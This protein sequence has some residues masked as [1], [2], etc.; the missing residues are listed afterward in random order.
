MNFDEYKGKVIFVGAG[1]GAPDLITV[2]GAEAVKNADVIIYAGSLVNPAI[3]DMA[4]DDAKIYDSAEMNLDEIIDVI[5]TAH[6]EN[7]I[8]ARVHT[9]DPSIYG[10][11]AEQIN[12]L[13]ELDIEFTIIPGVSSLFGTAA[14]LESQLTLPE[15]SQTIIITRPEGRTPKPSKEALAKLATHNATMCI[16]LGIHMIEEVVEELKKEYDAKTPVA[17]VKKATW[18]DQE[19][20]RGNLDNIAQ[21]VHEAGFTKT[22]MIV[23]GDVLD[24][25]SGEQSKLYDP[26]FAHMYRDAKDDE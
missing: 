7:K 19:I 6:E 20:L 15:V 2:R 14:A 11:I 12:Q 13:R 21:K 10:A 8:T 16:F 1:P 22:A 18:P 24:Q 17:I 25:Q 3:L 9:G 5:K 26:H 23:V 4:K